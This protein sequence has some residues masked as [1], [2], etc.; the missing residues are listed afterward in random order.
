MKSRAPASRQRKY[1]TD[2]VFRAGI[3][4]VIGAGGQQSVALVVRPGGRDDPGSGQFRDL[5]GRDARGARRRGDD[6]RFALL[7][8]AHVHE[9]AVG[10]QVIDPDGAGIAVG[11]A[12]RSLRKPIRIGNEVIRGPPVVGNVDEFRTRQRTH[13]VARL[14]GRI[15]VRLFYD[16]TGFPADS[17]RQAG[18]D[19]VDA[20][21]AIHVGTI[22]PDG[23]HPDQHFMRLGTGDLRL[24]QFENVRRPERAHHRLSHGAIRIPVAGACG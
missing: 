14:E 7:Q 8:L 18:L 1:T 13:A 15:L 6:D 20:L 9:C 16:A 21:P 19:R 24:D 4:D 12:V 3:D 23:S 11:D 17:A 2:V 5:D 22:H 10:G